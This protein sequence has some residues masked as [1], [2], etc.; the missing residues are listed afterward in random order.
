MATHETACRI[1]REHSTQRFTPWKVGDKVWLEATNLCLCY[2]SRK[3]SP[4][5]QGSFEVAQVLSPLTYH[6]QLPFT[7]RIHNVFHAALLS[8]YKETI[9]HGLNFLSPLPV[10]IKSEEEYKVDRIVS[11]KG[12]PK[13]QK[14]LTA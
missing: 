4:K 6:L 8:P 14:Y 2:P 9:T 5:Q 11:H 3:L 10:M 12:S 13:Q 7:W 1:I